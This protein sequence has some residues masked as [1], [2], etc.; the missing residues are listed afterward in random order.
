MNDCSLDIFGR[1]HILTSDS[2]FESRTKIEK[3]IEQLLQKSNQ[4][5][6]LLYDYDVVLFRIGVVYLKF[7]TNT[8]IKKSRN[9]APISVT[10]T[11][12]VYSIGNG[13]IKTVKEGLFSSKL[14]IPV[15]S[16]VNKFIKKA[17]TQ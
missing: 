9:T 3:C 5:F 4:S 7:R 11:Y 6:T 13:P 8:S 17:K 2:A 10:T 12:F 1:L 14:K 15:K 16:I